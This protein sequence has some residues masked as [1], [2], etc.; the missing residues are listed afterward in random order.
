MKK[1]KRICICCGKEYEYCTHCG[2]SKNEPRWKTNYDE[3]GCKVAFQT[4]TDYLAKEIT[5]EE[6]REVLKNTELKN[7]DNF[8]SSVAKYVDEILGDKK[9]KASE[10]HEVNDSESKDIAY[11]ASDNVNVYSNNFAKSNKNPDGFKYDR[12]NRNERKS[13]L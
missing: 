11:I 1:N 3:Y 5:A 4:V 10:S 12:Y 7:R 13:N 6:A 9:V 2:D 8:K